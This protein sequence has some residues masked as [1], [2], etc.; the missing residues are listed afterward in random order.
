MM[1][2]HSIEPLPLKL[3]VI[4]FLQ[5]SVTGNIKIGKTRKQLKI[6]MSHINGSSPTSLDLLKIIENKNARFENDL[7]ARFIDYRVDG[8]K[9]WFH[10][11]ESLMEFISNSE[12]FKDEKSLEPSQSKLISE[13][14]KKTKKIRQKDIAKK[15]GIGPAMLS[16]IMN[17]KARPSWPTAKRLAEVTGTDPVLWL[18]G[19]PEELQKFFA[20]FIEM[21]AM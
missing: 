5:C 18:E 1:N 4:Y 2:E 15:A 20:E 11:D 17:G 12:P 16:G 6:R 7:H 14:N 13:K 21:E 9:E 3:G 10:C 19:T 8:K